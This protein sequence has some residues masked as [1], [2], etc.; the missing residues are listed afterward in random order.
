MTNDKPFID[1][2]EEVDFILNE[3]N[4]EGISI[5]RN[6]IE[7]ILDL[8]LKFLELKGIATHT[9]DSEEE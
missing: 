6:T 8:D 5:D 9:E 7:F 3:C 2:D 4:K 1:I